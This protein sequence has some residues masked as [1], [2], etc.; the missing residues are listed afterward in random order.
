V[1][2]LLQTVTVGDLHIISAPIFT[3]DFVQSHTQPET[4]MI[5]TATSVIKVWTRKPLVKQLQQPPQ[6]ALLANPH[7]PS[8]G[9]LMSQLLALLLLTTFL[10]FVVTHSQVVLDPLV[11][12]RLEMILFNASLL[13]H[14]KTS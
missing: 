3:Y 8:S 11:W 2:E 10:N 14:Q 7:P 6:S 9:M 1:G 5:I 4:M 12:K 13:L